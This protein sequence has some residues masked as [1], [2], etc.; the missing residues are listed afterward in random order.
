MCTSDSRPHL[1]ASAYLDAIVP[2]GYPNPSRDS[3]SRYHC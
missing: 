1:D 2:Y 3:Y